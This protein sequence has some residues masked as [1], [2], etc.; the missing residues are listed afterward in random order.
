MTSNHEVAGSSPAFRKS[1]F[2]DDVEYISD[3]TVLCFI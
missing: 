1:W 3:L 2:K